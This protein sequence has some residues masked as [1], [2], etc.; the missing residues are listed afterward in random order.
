MI[1]LIKRY[2]SRKLYDTEESRYVSLDDVA[3][4]V[5][6]GQQVRVVDNGTAEDV[7][8]QTLTQIILDEGRKGTSFL[9]SELLHELVRIGERAV[10][11][12]VEQLQHG[13]DRVLKASMDRLGPVRRAREEMSSLRQRLEELETSLEA[14]ERERTSGTAT[15]ATAVKA[16]APR[17]LASTAARTTGRRPRGG[18]PRDGA[19]PG[20]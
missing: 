17:P 4:W 8:A 10:T 18:D 1:R 5:R 7:T 12:G 20:T 19:K 9:P 6:A 3:G 16:R 11:N 13:V 14:L 15:A 2:E